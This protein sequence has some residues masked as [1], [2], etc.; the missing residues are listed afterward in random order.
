MKSPIFLRVFREKC[1]LWEEIS[2]LMNHFA[3]F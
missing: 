2:D 3:D 1:G